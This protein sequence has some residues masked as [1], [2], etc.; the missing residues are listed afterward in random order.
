MLSPASVSRPAVRSLLS[1]PRCAPDRSWT[2]GA[3]LCIRIRRPEGPGG[4]VR[5]HGRRRESARCAVE[6][7]CAK[8]LA[9]RS[10][11]ACPKTRCRPSCQETRRCYCGSV[12]WSQESMSTLPGA[13]RLWLDPGVGRWRALKRSG[14]EIADRL[15]A[16][17]LWMRVHC[18]CTPRSLLRIER[19]AEAGRGS[20]AAGLAHGRDGDVVARGQPRPSTEPRRPSSAVGGHA[21]SPFVLVSGGFRA[22]G[23]VGPC[24][25][26]SG[27]VRLARCRRSAGG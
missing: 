12:A 26:A 22:F 10:P 1:S 20:G 2:C 11:W 25:H 13:T 27:G 5:G 14:E 16:R 3:P 17:G 23:P 24:V 7:H 15:P 6:G 21:G 9:V 19:S 18:R 8:D 4:S